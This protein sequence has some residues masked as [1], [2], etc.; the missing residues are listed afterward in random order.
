MLRNLVARHAK[1]A[2]MRLKALRAPLFRALHP[3]KETFVC[4]ACRYCGPFMDKRSRT[5]AKCP[6]CGALE[7]TRLHF[8]VLERI[9]AS[10]DPGA[11]SILH[12]AP[13][14]ILRR[15]L[16]RWFGTYRSGDLNRADVDV[17][18]D[19]QRL[20]FADASFDCVFAS[21]VLEYPADDVAAI[22]E[23]RRVL[24]PGGLAVLPV[25]LMGQHT[26]DLAARDPVTR[27]MH[28]PGLDYVERFRARFERVD[29]VRS[30][31]V[32]ARFQPF[33]RCPDASV[34]MPLT[35]GPGVYV[36]TVPLCYV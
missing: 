12:I 13:E 29:L 16:R 15:H 17:T 25:P 27:M 7:R 21:H 22:T 20:P 4:P 28:E 5:D 1:D 31:E 23:V 14:P 6:R 24:R 26:V 33:V 8:A 3:G 10:F 35:A 9:L 30:D 19:I 11:K 34:P 36:D 32:D 18:L 2:E